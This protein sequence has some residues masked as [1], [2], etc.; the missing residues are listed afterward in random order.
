MRSISVPCGTSS[1]SIWPANI[2][3]C[4]SG[5]RPIWLAIALRTRFALTS[6]PMPTPGSAVSL[7]ITVRSRLR[8][9]TN[10]STMYSGV[11]TPMNPPTM[12]LAPSGMRATASSSVM[13]R[14]GRFR[15]LREPAAVDRHRCAADLRGGFGAQERGQHADLLGRRE[16]QRRLLFAEELRLRL[17]AGELLARGEIVDLLL[18]ERR[19]DKAGANRIARDARGRSFQRDDLGEAQHAMFRRDIG[20]LMRRSDQAVRRRDIHDAPPVPFLHLRQ[21]RTDR[22]EHGGKID[23]ENRIPALDGK[24][25]DWCRE[26]NAGIVD[27]DVDAAELARRMLDHCDDVHGARHVRDRK[28]TRLNSSHRCISY[29]VFCLKKK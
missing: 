29:A 27:E 14:I 28:S 24:F 26:L 18:H 3:F 6:L 23:R 25:V 8:C 20:G 2:F 10:S 11:P 22:V 4:V 13:V 17:R 9:L 5:L 7:P 19:Q 1:T 15:L 21:H 12:R 16:F